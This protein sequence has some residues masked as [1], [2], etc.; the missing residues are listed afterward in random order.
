MLMSLESV[1]VDSGVGGVVQKDFR[2]GDS[3]SLLHT[4]RFLCFSHGDPTFFSSAP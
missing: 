4:H 1:F 2:T 3:L